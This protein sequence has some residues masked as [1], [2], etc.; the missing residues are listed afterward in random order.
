MDPLR[1]RLRSN[2]ISPARRG[3]IYSPK[4]TYQSI[5]T[6][7]IQPPAVRHQIITANCKISHSFCLSCTFK[8]LIF[9]LSCTTRC[10]WIFLQEHKPQKEIT[11]SLPPPKF[12][13]KNMKTILIQRVFW[14]ISWKQR[15]SCNDLHSSPVQVP[16]NCTVFFTL[17][18]SF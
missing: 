7:S 14:L 4:Q 1:A 10:I 6:N 16:R 11:A 13:L 5:N 17:F 12:R 18:G 2:T 3:W 9:F 15:L 8:P